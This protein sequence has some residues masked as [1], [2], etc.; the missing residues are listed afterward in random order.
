MNYT[1]ENPIGIDAKIQS[2][3]NVLYSE[4]NTKWGLSGGNS[5]DSYGRVYINNKDGKK[6]PEFYDQDKEYGNVLVA[7]T[8]KF[9]FIQRRV[10]TKQNV[11][12]YKTVVELC[13]LVDLELLKSTVGHRADAEVHADV[14][15]VLTTFPNVF[16][17]FFSLFGIS[18]LF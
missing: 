9:F 4:L 13:F 12:Q 16:I 7:E 17:E 14:E 1:K 10:Q 3:Q 2:M 18:V 15:S 5:L 8:S 6:I 11:L